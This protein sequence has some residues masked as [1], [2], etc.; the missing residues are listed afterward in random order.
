VRSDGVQ[1][2]AERGRPAAKNLGGVK[3]RLEAL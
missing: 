2:A 1:N 3:W